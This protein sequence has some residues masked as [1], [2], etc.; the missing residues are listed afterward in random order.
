MEENFIVCIPGVWTN[1]E[2]LIKSVAV[3][4][5]GEFM[6]AG[7]ILAHPKGNDHIILEFYEAY[8]EM[9]AA[10]EYGGQGQLSTDTLN[11]ISHHKSVVYLIFPLNVLA[12]KQRIAKFTKILSNCGGIAIKV[13]NS[14]V[15][16][17]WNDWFS[18]I[19]SKNPFDQYSASVILV[20]DEKYYYSCGM[21]T[22]N[23]PDSEISNQIAPEDATD[24]LNQF[25]YWRITENP[26]LESGHTFS[27]SKDSPHFRL[28]LWQDERHPSDDLFHNSN[29]VWSL[30]RF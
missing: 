1:R 19:E 12:Q 7:E 2:E 27:L 20:G 6:F 8:D 3:S 10:F 15:A 16:H 17:E 18:K 23:L 9:E 5:G 14:G 13:E 11:K 21:H 22:F 25:N 29:G 28:E 4:T 26:Q 30:S 24:L